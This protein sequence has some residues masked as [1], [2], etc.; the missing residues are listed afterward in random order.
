ML[1]KISSYISILIDGDSKQESRHRQLDSI[2]Q[3]FWNRTLPDLGF[4]KSIPFSRAEFESSPA[5]RAAARREGEECRRK[6]AEMAEGGRRGERES[7]Q[8]AERKGTS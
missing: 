7:T 5:E 6:R 1:N 3:A 4:R 2:I 8:Q